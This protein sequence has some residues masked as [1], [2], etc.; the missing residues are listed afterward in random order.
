MFLMS[1]ASVLW[2]LGCSIA[3]AAI[4]INVWATVRVLRFPF[5][6][7]QRV[8]QVVLIWLI[9]G[10]C[11][12]SLFVTQSQPDH[13]SSCK[14]HAADFFWDADVRHDHLDLGHSD[15]DHS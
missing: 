12:L 1:V 8:A 5:T 14:G 6:T 2:V 13:G 9:P 7:R 3:A 11:L 15:V 4:G 10:F